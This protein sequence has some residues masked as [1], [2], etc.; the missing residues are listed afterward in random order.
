MR[1]RWRRWLQRKTG[2]VPQARPVGVPTTH[3]IAAIPSPENRDSVTDRCST[4][5]GD[6]PGVCFYVLQ[7]VRSARLLLDPPF[8]LPILVLI[9]LRAASRARRSRWIEIIYLIEGDVVVD[10]VILICLVICFTFMNILQRVRSVPLPASRPPAVPVLVLGCPLHARTAKGEF[11]VGDE[12]PSA[13]ILDSSICF[14][15]RRR[16]WWRRRRRRG[17]GRRR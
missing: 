10:E 12:F 8:A 2:K 1:W 13:L 3:R 6:E 15:R 11:S 4:I 7:Y 16:R 9:G 5:V 17:G 14:K